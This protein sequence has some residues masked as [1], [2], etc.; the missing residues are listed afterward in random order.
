MIHDD[1]PEVVSIENQSFVE[2]MDEQ[3]LRE[4]RQ[5][6]R[7][8]GTVCE[9]GQQIVGYCLVDVRKKYVEIVRLAVAPALR[10]M[11]VGT[12]QIKNLKRKYRKKLVTTVCEEDLTAQLFLKSAGFVGEY[13]HGSI[14]FTHARR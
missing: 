3:R 8:I 12:Q 10:R 11:T 7:V 6:R 13:H 2:P 1:V 5:Q 9:D 14:R 4:L